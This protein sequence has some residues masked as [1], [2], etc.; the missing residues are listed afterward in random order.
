[1]DKVE[2]IVVGAGPAGSACA[3]ELARRGVE[4]VV[5]ER[6][7]QVGHK[8]VASFALFGTVLSTIIPGYESEAPLERL[9]RDL[10]M[11]MLRDDD[12]LE[13]RSRLSGLEAREPIHTAYR[14]KFDA[15][16]ASKAEEAGATLLRGVCVTGLLKENG[17]VV[18][19]KVGDEEMLADVVVGADGFHSVVSRESGLYADDTSRCMLGI[20]E[21][22]G[23][24]P[25]VIEERFNLLPGEGTAKD[26]ISCLD[27]VNGLFSLYTMNDSVTIV[28]F[29]TMDDIREKGV[30]LR[31]GLERFKDHPYIHEFIKGSELREYESHIIADG[32][33]LKMN[34]LYTD[35]VLLCGD[36]GAIVNDMYTGVPSCMLSGIKA[37]E[38]VAYAKQQRRYDAAT[39]AKYKEILYTT[40]LPR[41]MFNARTF[42]DFMV[43]SGWKNLGTFDGKLFD[44]GWDL[45]LEDFNYLGPEPYHV[46][47]KAYD[48]F[49]GPYVRRKWLK[50][51]LE[52]LI[53][54]IDKLA[55]WM[56][57]R[58]IRRAE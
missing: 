44:F 41:I 25:E 30:N 9:V 26:G 38:T 13:V 37:A 36:A 8:N 54:A 10:S 33:R 29:A 14:S 53:G 22:L 50:R 32:G 4:T 45:V 19:V 2:C 11:V 28:L 43:K 3:I 40:G 57:K 46:A 12:F 39:L 21:V 47:R 7:E 20:K 52:L 49:V 27:G 23:L 48:A 6:G 51:M 56:K 5:L 55:G 18:G 15:W 1:M 31:E 17:R 34:Q 35:G 16:F 42:S 58:K 24:P